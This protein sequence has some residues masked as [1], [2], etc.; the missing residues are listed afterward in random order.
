MRL[1][2]ALLTTSLLALTPSAYASF[3][4]DFEPLPTKS[5]ADFTAVGDYYQAAH[6]VTFGPSAIALIDAQAPGGGGSGNFGNAPSRWTALL[7]ADL[8]PTAGPISSFVINVAG[9]FETAFSLFYTTAASATLGSVAVFDAPD[10]GGNQIGGFGLVQQGTSCPP[11]TPPDF[12]STFFCW[13]T[14]TT[15]FSGKAFSV[16]ITGSDMGFL[17]DNLKFG[18]T[19]VPE[20]ASMALSLVGLAALALS[21]RRKAEQL[22]G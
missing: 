17:F 15:N 3:V 20:P 8:A 22:A 19:K 16:K 10:A 9:G 4:L 13:G 5:L 12:A 21:R 2:H 1:I 18:A 7:L 6:G 14:D 11:P